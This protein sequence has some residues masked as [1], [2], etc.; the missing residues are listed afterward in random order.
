MTA[1]VGPW[2]SFIS[3]L[4]F[5]PASLG[6]VMDPI[7]WTRET[8]MRTFHHNFFNYSNLASLKEK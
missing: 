3:M 1:S 7:W 2:T 4:K 8:L 5:Y 6:F